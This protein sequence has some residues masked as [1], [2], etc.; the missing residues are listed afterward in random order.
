LT[1]ASARAEVVDEGDHVYLETVLP[2]AFDTI[3]PPVVT[4]A[5]LAP[6]RF[7]DAEFEEPEGGPAMPTTD[8]VG[9]RKDIN[10]S[11]SAGPIAL[12]SSGAHR[13]RIW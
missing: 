1:D 10:G 12:L 5:D 2:Q 6:V 13:V 3:R 4:G 8:L 11:Y 9:L 7:V